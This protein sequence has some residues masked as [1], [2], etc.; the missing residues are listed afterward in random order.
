[1]A[2]IAQRNGCHKLLSDAEACGLQVSADGNQIKLK[3]DDTPE[4]NRIVKKLSG[5]PRDEV[6][7]AINGVPEP[8]RESELPPK[9]T[10]VLLRMQD[11][12]PRTVQWL[13]PNR[14]AAGRMTLIVG[15]PGV[16]KSFIECDMASRVSTGT[17]WPD[18]TKCSKGSVLLVCAEDDPHDTI[19]PRL[20]A[21]HADVSRIH[22]L[23]GVRRITDEGETREQVFTLSNL[24]TL[25]ST[26]KQL[27][28]CR[29]VIIDPIGSYL[30]GHTDAHRDNEV[31]SVLA[32]VAKLAEKYG[33]AVVVIAHRRKSLSTTADE[34][35]LGS[36]A[37]TGLA[38]AVWHV[39]QDS[40]DNSR[41]LFL[42]GKNNL[43]AEQPGLAFSISGEPS[44]VRWESDPVDLTADEAFS[45]EGKKGENT[46]ALDEAVMWLEG[47]LVCGPKV[48]TEV[49]RLAA[50]DCIAYRTLERAKSKLGVVNGPDGFGGPWV[51]K[52]P[53]SANETPVSAESAKDKTLADTDDTGGN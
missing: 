33:P 20:D 36:R 1:M 11:V 24:E 47:L 41:R 9:W 13:W 39:C 16:G 10:P 46:S 26:L 2:D 51:W 34:S 8:P 35:A 29:L 27:D 30:G 31:R 44:C 43:A 42:P 49:Q 18:G 28:D 25:E 40:K 3:G 23:S 38:R 21:H 5:Q 37:F 17:P 53:E 6:L 7:R 32:P 4:V 48:G 12:E 22:L 52:L 50:K 15:V 19:R 45:A 14:I